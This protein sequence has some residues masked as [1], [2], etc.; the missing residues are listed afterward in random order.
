MK[1]RKPILFICILLIA[2]IIPSSGIA[3]PNNIRVLIQDPIENYRSEVKSIDDGRLAPIPGDLPDD[4]VFPESIYNF[5]KTSI[6]PEKTL[7]FNNEV[8]VEIL[9]Q[10]D[11]SIILGYLENITAFGPRVTESPECTAAGNYIYNEFLN[12]GIEARIDDWSYDG[13][14]D[15]NI[16][17]TL[18]GI[19]ESNDEIFIICAHYDSVPGSPGADDDGSGTAAVLA[20]ANILSQYQFNFTIRF[21]AFSGEEQGLLGS[22]EYV[23]EADANGDNIIA[24]LNADMIGFAITENDGKKIKIYENE[25]S[26]WITDFTILVC[27][28]YYD[29]IE[30]DIIPSGFTWSSD[31]YSFWEFGYDAVF[32]HEYH[33]N[34]YYHSPEDIIE[35]MNITY[36]KKSTRL[37]IAT[38]VEL[39]QAY[40]IGNPPDVPNTPDGPTEGIE[41]VEL[42][43]STSTIDPD[44]DQ[45][46]YKFDWGDGT[47]SYWLGPYNSGETIEASNSWNKVGIYDVRVK[48][49][50]INNRFSG[51]S[52]PLQVT[53]ADNFP[54]EGPTIKGPR[55]GRTG[56]TLTFSLIS[57]DP[58]NHD[59]YYYVMWGDGTFD[60]WSG[61]YKSG[62]ELKINHTYSVGGQIEIS[63]KAKDQYQ[64]EGDQVQFVIFI[65][66]DRSVS[67]PILLRFMERLIMHFPRLEFILNKYI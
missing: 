7:A 26:E 37:I 35:N 11:E 45:L 5:F 38:L 28:E 52:E 50:D 60:D 47:Y 15:R 34:E 65:I 17:G 13:Y 54:P 36:S 10:I 29:Y 30:L 25:N 64:Q 42:T 40:F 53:I 58:E 39:G 33:F 21:V 56:K 41:G 43:F 62:D 46:Y 27:E 23:E 14:S 55:I 1:N 49:R 66:K 2:Y 4:F 22:H 32:Y 9:T 19:N 3:I 67:S 12:L 48:A 61:P 63:V 59:I 20:A 8:I 18:E 6:P 44:G 24:A 51:W 16:E 31:H 57:S